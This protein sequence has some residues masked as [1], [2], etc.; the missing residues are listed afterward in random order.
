M[1]IKGDRGVV[2]YKVGTV[3]VLYGVVECYVMNG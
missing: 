3:F 2:C 1:R